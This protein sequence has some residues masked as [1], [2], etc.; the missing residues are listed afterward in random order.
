MESFA[1]TTRELSYVL[2]AYGEDD[3]F[4]E[5]N[6]QPLWMVHNVELSDIDA[7]VNEYFEDLEPR[8]YRYDVDALSSIDPP[9]DPQLLAEYGENALS[10]HNIRLS[11]G[12]VRVQGSE[13]PEG[14]SVYVAGREVPVDETGNFVSEEV[15]PEGAHTVEVAV[16]DESGRGESYLRDVAFEPSDWFYVG[17][18]DLTCRQVLLT[19]RWTN[20]PETMHP[21]SWIHQQTAVCPSM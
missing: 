3:D 14:H 1:G 10:M 19:E 9:L 12:T 15:L 6:L 2:R 8:T 21:T 18:A 7:N 5:T 17:M 20:S 13:V 4:D 16:V 11:S